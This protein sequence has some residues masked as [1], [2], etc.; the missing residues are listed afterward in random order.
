MFA[1]RPR[2][3]R[4]RN[5]LNRESKHV[6]ISFFNSLLVVNVLPASMVV[7]QSI[8][9]RKIRARVGHPR[10]DDPARPP[11]SKE[12]PDRGLRRRVTVSHS[13]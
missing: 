1:E 6:P 3:K 7:M 13:A 2:T 9:A 12:P 8:P 4:N 5:G 10:E 11:L